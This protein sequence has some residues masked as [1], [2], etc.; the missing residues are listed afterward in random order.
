MKGQFLLRH[1]TPKGFLRSAK[2]CHESIRTASQGQHYYWHAALK[3]S[4]WERPEA[5][6]WPPLGRGGEGCVFFVCFRV[7][8]GSG[9]QKHEHRHRNKRTIEDTILSTEVSPRY[10]PDQTN[11]KTNNNKQPKKRHGCQQSS[12]LVCLIDCLFCCLN[13]A[14]EQAINQT[15]KDVYIVLFFSALD[16]KRSFEKHGLR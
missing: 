6:L 15:R 11:M 2:P 5:T 13:Q 9:T 12:I 10:S 8:D 1:S 3:K 7:F 16:S 14:T 4:T